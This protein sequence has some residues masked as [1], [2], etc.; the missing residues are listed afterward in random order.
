VAARKC[1]EKRRGEKAD[2]QV[3]VKELEQRSNELTQEHDSL[4]D[5]LYVLKN[6]AL[7][8]V[9]ADCDTLGM[10]EACLVPPSPA[11]KREEE[12]VSILELRECE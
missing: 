8:H 12:S 10:L 9:A 2:L 3:T 11:V 4:R 1:R 5:T 7:G 6:I